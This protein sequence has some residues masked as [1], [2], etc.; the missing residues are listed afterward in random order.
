MIVNHV[1][2][3]P[4]GGLA[5]PYTMEDFKREVAREHLH[6][7]TAEERLAGLPAEQDAYL[8]RLR[9]RPAKKGKKKPRG[10]N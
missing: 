2:A 3:I 9:K 1:R 10:Q 8:K 7:L 5:M 4:G 6:E